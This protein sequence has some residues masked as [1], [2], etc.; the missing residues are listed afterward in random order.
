LAPKASPVF[1]GSITLGSRANG[2][3]NGTNSLTVGDKCRAVSLYAV[4]IGDRT[5]SEGNGTIAAGL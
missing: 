4:A 5:R 1:T 3:P 2:S